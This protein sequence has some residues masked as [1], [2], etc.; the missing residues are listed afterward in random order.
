MINWP[1]LTASTP[2]TLVQATVPSPWTTMVAF[3]LSVPVLGP[4][5]S[6]CHTTGKKDA[7]K[8]G[9]VRARHSTAQNP[10]SEVPSSL[11]KKAQSPVTH[12]SWQ[13]PRWSGL[14]LPAIVFVHILA[15]WL[16]LTMSCILLLKVFVLPLPL[17]LG[18]S[19][20]KYP[21][22]LDTWRL[23]SR[24]EGVLMWQESLSEVVLPSWT[25]SWLTGACDSV[26]SEVW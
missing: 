4:L 24:P 21:Q 19:S 15:S 16:V 5:R 11:W 17:A 1:L 22:H 26:S 9:E 25:A 3:E 14:S 20:S 6:T 23:R 2:I 18:C 8:G 10:T 7:F 13:G 12:H